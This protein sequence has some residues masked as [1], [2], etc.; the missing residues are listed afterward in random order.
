[1]KL[2]RFFW[3]LFFLLAAHTASA[4]DPH[5]VF[6]RHYQAI[7]GIDR[8][9]ALESSYSE[10]SIRYDGLSGTFRQWEKRPILSRLEEDFSTIQQVS[11]DDGAFSW[12]L[13]TNGRVLVYR[14]RE[15]Q[16]RRDLAR[17]MENFEHLDPTSKIFRLS[18]AGATRLHNRPHHLVRLENTLN[19]D[20]GLYFFDT[21][22]FMLSRMEVRLP[23][24]TT[25]TDAGDFRSIRGFVVPFD[26]TTRI[27][28]RGKRTHTR[29]TTYV[30]DAK[31]DP[32]LFQIPRSTKDFTLDP[33]KGPVSFLR[34]GGN[35]FL[36]VNVNGQQNYWLLDS[37]ASMTIVDRDYGEKNGQILPG[38]IQG[39]GFGETFSLGFARLP[40]F[41]SGGLAI[42]PQTVFAFPGLSQRVAQPRIA[43]ILGYDF[44]S[45]PVS[46]IDFTEKTIRFFDPDTFHYQGDGVTLEAPLKYRTFAVPATL[47]GVH[48]GHWSLDLGA[49]DTSLFY[50]FAA[51]HGYLNQPGAE[52]ESRGLAGHFSE[53]VIQAKTLA[54][55]PF[56]IN[57]PRIA[58]PLEAGTGSTAIGEMLGNIGIATLSNFVVWLDYQR[59]Q[60]ILEKKSVGA[61]EKK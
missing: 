35:I 8:L 20:I 41:H 61:V 19:S 46:R 7:G 43:G 28:P 31:T 34:T 51:Q 14:D 52:R 5:A 10:G 23:D 56:V 32:A 27:L 53:R 17:R 15:T 49:D 54:I 42:G 57:G 16:L 21:A 55:G 4:V 3:V 59:Q 33:G 2:F 11:G 26:E 1:M 45:R 50:P 60:V 58:V 18:Y 48:S 36:P 22:T 37:G 40:G 9:K 24:V 30:P 12:L 29:L 39:F 13:D 44:L 25:I 47:D 38:S 6:R